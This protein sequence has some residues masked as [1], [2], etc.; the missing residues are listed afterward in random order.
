MKVARKI[1]EI[2]AD[3]VRLMRRSGRLDQAGELGDAADQREF[4]LVGQPT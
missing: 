4:R 1:I 3:A 2:E